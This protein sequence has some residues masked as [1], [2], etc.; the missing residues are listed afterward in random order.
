MYIY[1]CTCVYTY[2]YT[3]MYT[4]MYTTFNIS[5]NYYCSLDIKYKIFF[6]I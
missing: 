1:V 2:V 4:Y 3:Y 6:N 5:N